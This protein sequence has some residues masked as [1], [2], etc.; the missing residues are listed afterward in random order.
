M[1]RAAT[2]AARCHWFRR[3][4]WR[5]QLLA[6]APPASQPLLVPAPLTSP[7]CKTCLPSDPE[8]VDRKDPGSIPKY[9]PGVGECC[10]TS[11][12]KPLCI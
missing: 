2:G 7:L 10:C 4:C 9:M 3:W 11:A 12:L 5:R 1:E 8:W 6:A